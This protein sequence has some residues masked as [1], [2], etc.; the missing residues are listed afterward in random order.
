MLKHN[1]GTIDRVI[2]IVAGIALLAY[3]VFGAG[4]ARWFGLVGIVPLATAFLSF[5]PAYA[6][7]GLST[8]QGQRAG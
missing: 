3:A 5:C 8:C 6:F 1:V 4:A 7:L 2:R